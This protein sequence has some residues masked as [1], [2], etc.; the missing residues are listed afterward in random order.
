MEE[1]VLVLP[2]NEPFWPYTTPELPP[3]PF[4]CIQP[5]VWLCPG[6]QDRSLNPLPAAGSC[7]SAKPRSGPV[8]PGAVPL[9]P[10]A[11]ARRVTESGGCGPGNGRQRGGPA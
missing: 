10:A 9:F 3:C 7:R 2:G 8:P 4:R 1:P 11:P 5:P 6:L